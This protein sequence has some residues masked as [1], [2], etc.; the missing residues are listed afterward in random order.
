MCVAGARQPPPSNEIQSVSCVYIGLL[1]LGK[2][3]ARTFRSC[4]Y[5]AFRRVEKEI[6]IKFAFL[7]ILNVWK[8]YGFRL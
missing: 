6:S 2:I 4:F 8:I 5:F 7:R 1:F 3:R